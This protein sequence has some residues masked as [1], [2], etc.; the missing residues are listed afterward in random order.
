MG[1]GSLHLRDFDQ[2]F[3]NSVS[4]LHGHHNCELDHLSLHYMAAVYAKKAEIRQKVRETFEKCANSSEKAAAD[5]DGETAERWCYE[6]QFKMKL[7]KVKLTVKPSR[8]EQ[9]HMLLLK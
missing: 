5:D 9:Q 2:S 7:R 8:K 4:V 6:N 1:S 3:R